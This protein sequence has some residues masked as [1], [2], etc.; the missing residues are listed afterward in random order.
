MMGKNYE[1]AAEYGRLASRKARKAASMNEAIDYTYKRIDSLENLPQTENIQKNIIDARTNL[2]LR[3]T[4][5]NHVVE[6]KDSVKP[7]L[8][9]AIKKGY[10]KRLSLINTILGQYY[11]FSEED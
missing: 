7:I 11:C 10:K 3:Y 9:L 4:E 5:I 1:K 8:D 2:G 6:S